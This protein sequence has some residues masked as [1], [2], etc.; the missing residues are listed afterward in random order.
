[1]YKN[2]AKQMTVLMDSGFYPP[3]LK[4]KLGATSPLS[5]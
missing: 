3:N 1:M 2:R 4:S 5:G